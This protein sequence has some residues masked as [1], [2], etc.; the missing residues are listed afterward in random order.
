M[1]KMNDAGENRPERVHAEPA[2]P[3]TKSWYEHLW[4]T[5]QETPERLEEAAK[6]LS[7]VIS[8]TLTLFLTVGKTSF[9]GVRLTGGTLVATSLWLL[10]LVLCLLVIFPWRYRYCDVS[11]DSIKRMHTK[12]VQVKY[13][14]LAAG[15]VLF[16]LALTIL[17][18]VFFDT[19]IR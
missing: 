3:D 12:I 17:V 1:S 5:Q 11:V 8:L 14:M 19:R 13:T 10:S 4:K 7:G 2:P 6:F 15:V 9:E 16:L 18:L